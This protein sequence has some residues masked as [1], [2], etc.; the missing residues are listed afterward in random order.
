[1]AILI[2]GSVLLGAV[3]GRFFKVLV[4]VPACALVLAVVLVRSADGEHG[5]LRPLLEFA[6][7]ITSLQIGYVFGLVSHSIPSV[8][9]RRGTMAVPPATRPV[10]GLFVFHPHPS[11][12]EKPSCPMPTSRTQSMR[13]LNLICAVEGSAYFSRCPG[14]DAGDLGSASGEA[15]TGA[16][17]ASRCSGLHIASP[18]E[19][20][21]RKGITQVSLSHECIG[22]A[23]TTSGLTLT[24]LSCS[25]D[26]DDNSCSHNESLDC[27]GRLGIV[28][29]NQTTSHLARE[30]GAPIVAVA[31][32]AS[33]KIDEADALLSE[34]RESAARGGRRYPR[35]RNDFEATRIAHDSVLLGS[36]LS[37]NPTQKRK[38]VEL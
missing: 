1:V 20:T 18:C 36:A 10:R 9:K 23:A 24:F 29:M 14:C 12:R 5:L 6:V 11:S 28:L 8:S 32:A 37:R 31:N 34:Y 26:V 7:L 22:M 27:F 13:T 2:L 25:R 35:D 21:N 17:P 15:G 38:R 3:L 4:L 30:F 33:Q 19:S 16:P